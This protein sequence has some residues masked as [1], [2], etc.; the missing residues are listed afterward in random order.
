MVLVHGVT[1]SDEVRNGAFDG[2]TR[3]DKQV[4]GHFPAKC[5]AV[6]R[7]KCDKLKRN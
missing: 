6:R 3:Q 4:L 7:R 1:D 5:A 2:S